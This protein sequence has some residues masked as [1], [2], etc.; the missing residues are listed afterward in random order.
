MVGRDGEVLARDLV[1][2]IRRDLSDSVTVAVMFS[3]LRA[4]MAASGDGVAEC[5]ERV[6]RYLLQGIHSAPQVLDCLTCEVVHVLP[7]I[8]G[9]PAC[10]IRRGAR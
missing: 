5:R 3:C 4:A 10:Y 2:R 8:G 9:I 1:E 6:G 7:P